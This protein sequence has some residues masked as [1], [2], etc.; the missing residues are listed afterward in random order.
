VDSKTRAEG[1]VSLLKEFDAC[2]RRYLMGWGRE[3][4]KEVLELYTETKAV[5]VQI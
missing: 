3:M 1:F 5:V 2:L 4:G